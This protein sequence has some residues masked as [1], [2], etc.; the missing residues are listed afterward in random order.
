MF[1]RVR[2]KPKQASRW[3]G[4]W[5][6]VRYVMT[7]FLAWLRLLWRC[8]RVIK[9]DIEQL[10]KMEWKG[11]VISESERLRIDDLILIV[12]AVEV[13]NKKGLHSNSE[14]STDHL[15]NSRIPPHHHKQ[16]FTTTIFLTINPYHRSFGRA[17]HLFIY[18]NLKST[19]SSQSLGIDFFFTRLINFLHA[20]KAF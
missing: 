20:H 12:W 2:W 13:E 4:G 17:L 15:L 9:R 3:T 11:V 6:N 14:S 8:M 1:E 16:S 19:C 7:T 10:L 5:L 18:C